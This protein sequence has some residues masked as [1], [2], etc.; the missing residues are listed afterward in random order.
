MLWLYSPTFRRIAIRIYQFGSTQELYL[1][2]LGCKQ[3]SSQV[4]WQVDQPKVS[5]QYEAAQVEPQCRVVDQAAGLDLLCD[6]GILLAIG[7]PQEFGSSF[8]DF[9][10]LGNSS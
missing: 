3:L 2:C 8:D 6:N 4:D 1:V 5:V 9:L 10:S 7:H